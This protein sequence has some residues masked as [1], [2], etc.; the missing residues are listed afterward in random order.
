MGEFYLRDYNE[1]AGTW[2]VSGLFRILVAALLPSTASCR[3]DQMVQSMRRKNRA[4]W[5]LSQKKIFLCLEE[6]TSADLA[7]LLAAGAILAP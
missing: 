7:P 2:T 3:A 5:K 4:S 1:T 6:A